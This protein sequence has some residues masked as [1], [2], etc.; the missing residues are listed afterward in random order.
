M[1]KVISHCERLANAELRTKR[2]KNLCPDAVEVFVQENVKTPDGRL[3]VKNTVKK[4]NPSELMD[5]Y[6]VNDFTIENLTAAGAIAN[7]KVC[8]LSGDV[9]VAADTAANM[10]SVLENIPVEEEN[11]NI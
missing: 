7:L 9:L 8:N 6:C 10:M 3:M 2:K 5:K 4:I 1:Y 11:K